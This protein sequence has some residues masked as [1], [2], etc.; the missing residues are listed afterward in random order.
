MQS[1][2]IELFLY[3]TNIMKFNFD[4]MNVDWDGRT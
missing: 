3:I 4:V 2:N 1:Q